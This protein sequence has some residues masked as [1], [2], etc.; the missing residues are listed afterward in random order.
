MRLIRAATNDEATGH[1]LFGPSRT[2]PD[3]IDPGTCSGY[4]GVGMTSAAVIGLFM[5]MFLGGLV[6]MV[7][8]DLAT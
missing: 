6:T 1:L 2:K 4:F 5:P 7:Q 3:T 8:I